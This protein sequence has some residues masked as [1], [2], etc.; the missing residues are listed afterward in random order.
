MSA[1]L[2]AGL[3]G[4]AYNVAIPLLAA[5]V[6]VC[7]GIVIIVLERLHPH[8]L[9]WNTSR[10]DIPTD[11]THALVSMA[12]V[13]EL[14]TISVLAG[15]ATL[16]A[17][18]SARLGVDLWPTHWP[19]LIQTALAL[20]IGELG[21]YWVHRWTHE[22]DLL[23]RLHA[24]HHSAPRLYFLNAAR[25]HPLDTAL[26]FSL[27]MAPLALLGCPASVIGLFTIVTGI[28]GL[29]QHCNVR[30]ALGPLNYIFSMAELHRWHHSQTIVEANHN[31]GANLIIWDLVFG[32]FFW[33]KDRSPPS[34][35]GIADMP[36][37][38]PDYWS[39]LK[40]PFRWAQ[41]MQR[42]QHR[43]PDDPVEPAGL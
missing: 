27:Q 29:F 14:L 36:L 19:L 15:V 25:F 28:H 6:T 13:P 33:P 7:A 39:Q 31:Y 37:F 30:L 23:W 43:E 21:G 34:E 41:T 22:Y 38:P 35:I 24:T 40:S 8:E 1:G 10:G 2:A 18:A 42:S 4:L 32:T 26:A 12:A 3:V 9:D 16:G 5:G 20:V 17:G 11:A